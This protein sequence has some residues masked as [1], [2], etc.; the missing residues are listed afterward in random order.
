MYFRTLAIRV[1]DHNL[2]L[3]YL[4]L[5]EF[6]LHN[7]VILPRLSIPESYFTV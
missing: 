6:L 2:Q 1:C 5:F 3:F 4:V 7:V